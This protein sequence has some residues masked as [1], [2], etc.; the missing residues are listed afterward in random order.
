MTSPPF[1][2]W[3]DDGI[4]DTIAKLRKTVSSQYGPGVFKADL[5]EVRDRLHAVCVDMERDGSAEDDEVLY[6]AFFDALSYITTALSGVGVKAAL[7]QQA[8]V[9]LE[10]IRAL[11]TAN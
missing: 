11:Q 4:Q 7:I 9:S 2:R 5:R 3:A 8:I 6:L 1:I 10:Q